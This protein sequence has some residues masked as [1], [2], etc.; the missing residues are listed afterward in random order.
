MR[1]Y[2]N[3]C[4]FVTSPFR[5][6]RLTSFDGAI[7]ASISFENL[8][9]ANGA[10]L[11]RLVDLFSDVICRRPPSSEYNIT[12]YV[13]NKSRDY[14]SSLGLVCYMELYL[15]MLLES[16]FKECGEGCNVQIIVSPLLQEDVTVWLEKNVCWLCTCII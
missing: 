6:I 1:L 4:H 9:D 5:G 12:K 16:F 3:P 10:A 14:G 11:M 2:L 15:V 7:A 8:A 13:I